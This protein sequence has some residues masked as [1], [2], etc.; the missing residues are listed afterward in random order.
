MFHTFGQFHGEIILE[1]GRNRPYIHLHL[2]ISTFPQH[3]RPKRA[4]R[5]VFWFCSPWKS[6]WEID[7][8]RDVEIDATLSLIS[9]KSKAPFRYWKACSSC[10]IWPFQVRKHVHVQLSG[11]ETE[12]FPP[13]IKR[14]IFG[15]ACR[16][17][18]ELFWGFTVLPNTHTRHST[19]GA[20]SLGKCFPKVVFPITK[21]ASL[22][23]LILH[24]IE[25]S[26]L[27]LASFTL[28]QCP[29]ALAP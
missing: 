10:E 6:E 25:I 7:G 22:P 16:A 11:L 24:V 17:K 4:P 3:R 9:K 15:L 26:W 27:H 28:S 21:R 1:S 2:M 19:L 8:Q 14:G 29:V 18:M 20:N 5:P 13:A 12:Y 23:R